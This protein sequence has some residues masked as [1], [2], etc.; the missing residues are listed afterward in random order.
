MIMKNFI[1]N[2]FTY[3]CF[4]RRYIVGDGEYIVKDTYNSITK[5]LLKR[6]LIEKI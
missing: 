2:L 3:T 1:K 6:E 5:T 4:C